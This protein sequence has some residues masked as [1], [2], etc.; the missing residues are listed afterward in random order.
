MINPTNELSRGAD[1]LSQTFYSPMISTS[2]MRGFFLETF[3]TDTSLTSWT[4]N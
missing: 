1:S 3:A 4:K 2:T